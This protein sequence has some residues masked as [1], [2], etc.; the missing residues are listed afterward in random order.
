M[1]GAVSLAAVVKAETLALAGEADTAVPESTGLSLFA[2]RLDFFL[3]L[4]F[5]KLTIP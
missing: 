2:T 3:F 1:G 5:Y 4:C